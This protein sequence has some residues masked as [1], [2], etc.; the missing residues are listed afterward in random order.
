[1]PA[2]CSS[3]ASSRRR[4]NARRV[5]PI[6]R[7]SAWN[8]IPRL[9][10]SEDRITT[11]ECYWLALQKNKYDKSGT[12]F[13]NLTAGP[14]ICASSC[15]Y[16]LDRGCKE[17]RSTLSTVLPR[18]WWF[19]FSIRRILKGSW[20]GF[21][22]FFLPLL[23]PSPLTPFHPSQSLIYRFIGSEMPEE[24]F[25][26]R[27]EMPPWFI[28]IF[29]VQKISKNLQRIENFKES[30]RILKNIWKWV[31]IWINKGL[32]NLLED[33]KRPAA[34][35]HRC[36]VRCNWIYSGFYY[37]N[38]NSCYDSC[39][40]FILMMIIIIIKMNGRVDE[41]ILRFV[42]AGKTPE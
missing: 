20:V 34:N 26:D 18:M 40:V 32:K 31:K 10:V 12:R 4:N 30:W 13:K 35:S 28:G 3:F 33:W 7:P 2:D 38:K 23:P 42:S 11:A 17:L 41:L 5:A 36:V 1:M 8:R 24:S 9:K 27:L 29:L 6:S 22:F 21:F 16:W 39:F 15:F 25:R 14:R 19:V 37:D